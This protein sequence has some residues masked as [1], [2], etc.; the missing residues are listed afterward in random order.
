MVKAEMDMCY[1]KK[2]NKSPAL[3]TEFE[4]LNEGSIAKF[5]AGNSSKNFEFLVVVPKLPMSILDKGGIPSA[6]VFI[7]ILN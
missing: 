2:I 5:D 7:I 1:A 4:K 6:A 3:C